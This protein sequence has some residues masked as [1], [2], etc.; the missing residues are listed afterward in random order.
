MDSDADQNMLE[1]D[2]VCRSDC[3][4]AQC[5]Q[6]IKRYKFLS[7]KIYLGQNISDKSYLTQRKT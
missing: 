1:I 6:K 3:A 4:R 2:L 7:P 5:G